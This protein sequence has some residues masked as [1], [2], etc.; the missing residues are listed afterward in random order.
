[1][2]DRIVRS[3]KAGRPRQNPGRSEL[4]VAIM[5]PWFLPRQTWK[6]VLRL[7]PPAW[8]RKMRYCF[9]DY[10]CIRCDK[11]DVQHGGCG[12]CRDCFAR[13]TRRLKSTLRRHSK[14]ILGPEKSSYAVEFQRR[15]KLAQRLLKGMSVSA[16][17]S[18][19]PGP[20][21]R[22]GHQNPARQLSGMSSYHE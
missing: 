14:E 4:H 10:G 9:D 20:Q 6:Q 7:L 1:M 21:R 17:I 18:P 15:A 19:E 2:S 11:K 8:K 5:Q 3:R 22:L 12:M 13:V 16:P